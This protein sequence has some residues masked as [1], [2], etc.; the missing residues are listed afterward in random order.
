MLGTI[1]HTKI[2]DKENQNDLFLLERDNQFVWESLG[3]IKLFEGEN[4]ANETDEQSLQTLTKKIN[5]TTYFENLT[6]GLHVLYVLNIHVKF[7][8]NRILF[9]IKSINLFFIHNL[10]LETNTN[11]NM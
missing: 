4:E 3:Q 8:S 5:M 9:T 7:H 2:Q 11:L 6:V 10:V 1:P